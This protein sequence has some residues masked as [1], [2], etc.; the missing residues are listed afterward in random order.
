MLLLLL[1]LV[2]MTLLILTVKLLLLLIVLMRLLNRCRQSQFW[3]SFTAVIAA[4][5]MFEECS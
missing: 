3:D 2:R 1:Q 4:A 5:V